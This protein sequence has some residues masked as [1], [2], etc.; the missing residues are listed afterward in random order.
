LPY[1]RFDGLC[2]VEASITGEIWRYSALW[3]VPLLIEIMALELLPMT[4][5]TASRPRYMAPPL[6]ARRIVRNCCAELVNRFSISQLLFT[7][8]VDSAKSQTY[9]RCYRARNEKQPSHGVFLL[10]MGAERRIAASQMA[11]KS[12]W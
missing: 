1:R 10:D 9:C 4:T 3:P 8:Q 6:N 5:E 12:C 2:I 11:S 7:E